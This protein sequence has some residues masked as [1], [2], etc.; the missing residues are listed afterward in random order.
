MYHIICKDTDYSY[1]SKIVK[2]NLYPSV[3]ECVQISKCDCFGEP[4]LCAVIVRQGS[5]FQREYRPR[6]P[7]VPLKASPQDCRTPLPPSFTILTPTSPGGI[8]A[9]V[10]TG[11]FQIP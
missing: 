9:A 4:L 8:V 6:G 5:L 1:Y 3:A 10:L 2:L 11:W 7:V